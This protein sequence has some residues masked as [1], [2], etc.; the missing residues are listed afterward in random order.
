MNCTRTDA[1]KQLPFTAFTESFLMVPSSM[2]SFYNTGTMVET[3]RSGRTQCLC[4]Q[5]PLHNVFHFLHRFRLPKFFQLLLL[6]FYSV[7]QTS[8]QIPLCSIRFLL[9]CQSVVLLY[10]EVFSIFNIHI[11]YYTGSSIDISDTR[12]GHN[13]RIIE[14][15]DSRHFSFNSF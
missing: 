11:F 15:H 5:T 14:F 3:T 7:C 9:T 1:N 6:F 13:D 12:N 2:T 4:S 10:S 8:L